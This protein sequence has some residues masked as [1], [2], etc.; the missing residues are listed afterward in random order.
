ESDLLIHLVDASSPQIENQIDSVNR[1]LG[2]LQLDAIPRLL[3]FN[4]I[5]LVDPEESKNRC[6]VYNAI[7]VSAIKRETLGRL[8]NEISERLNPAE[9]EKLLH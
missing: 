8:V 2:E 3:V 6:E 5:D 9:N 4:K 1:I 7:P